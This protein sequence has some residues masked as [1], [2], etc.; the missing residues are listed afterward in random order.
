MLA[1]LVSTASAIPL[2]SIALLSQ[3]FVHDGAPV[4]LLG[5]WATTIAIFL[6]TLV[7]GRLSD[8]MFSA[9]GLAGMAGIALAAHLATD[10]AAARGIAPLLS[11]IPAI[12]AIASSRRVILGHTLIAIVLAWSVS[13]A[14]DESLTSVLVSGVVSVSAIGLPVFMIGSLRRSL[15]FSRTCYRDLANTDPL[16]GLQNRRGFLDRIERY[17]REN[18]SD[19]KKVG[20]L[21]IDVDHFKQIND[22]YGHAAGDDVL[23][24]VVT[25][26]R[27]AVRKD[28][29]LGRFGGEEFTAFFASASLDE[30]RAVSESIR[31]S[32]ADS[33]DA[34][35]SIG[36][37]FCSV[38]DLGLAPSVTLSE[39]ID[40][41][42]RRADTLMY[43]AKA[44]GRN[45]IR[46]EH[47]SPISVDLLPFHHTD[48]AEPDYAHIMAPMA[49][50]PQLRH[51][52]SAA[53]NALNVHRQCRR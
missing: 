6:T 12:A 9:L 10:H 27:R 31:I 25:A 36:G 16:T 14:L 53:A 46:C 22:R 20:F 47:I 26:T 51:G 8:R 11:A 7:V 13:S 42:T 33:C 19:T 2:P 38:P 3:S 30:V 39:L 4:Y 32:V 49:I 15:E 5:V 40:V 48:S 18:P 50:T 28:V 43:A 52:T 45:T 1:V 44:A 17:A 35:V 23:T 34:T 21:V 37:I 41:L 29:L 24:D